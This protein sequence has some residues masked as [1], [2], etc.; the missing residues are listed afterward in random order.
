MAAIIR[1]DKQDK[2]LAEIEAGLAAVKQINTLLGRR[3][4]DD[5]L[6]QVVMVPQKGRGVK[7]D[8]R[9]PEKKLLFSLCIKQRARLVKEIRTKAEKYRISLDDDDLACIEAGESLEPDQG[10]ADDISQEAED[11]SDPYS[12]SDTEI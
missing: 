9:H 2:A 1:D 4:D 8:V 10:G 3:E 12:D 6:F 11:D 5:V 7:V